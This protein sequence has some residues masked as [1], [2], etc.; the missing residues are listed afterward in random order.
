MQV[1]VTLTREDWYAYA[2]YVAARMSVHRRRW[3]VTSLA[4]SAAIAVALVV[5]STFSGWHFDAP[6]ALIVIVLIYAAL[7][8]TAQL[9]RRST[10]VPDAW[11]GR[12]IYEFG[13]DGLVMQG[14]KSVARFDWNAISKVEETESHLILMLDQLSGLVIPKRDLAGADQV[15]VLKA[16][17]ARFMTSASP[18]QLPD[19]GS[20]AP[21]A[22]GTPATAARPL[23]R[24]PFL[25]NCIGGLRLVAFRSVDANQFAPSARQALLFALIAVLLWIGFDRVVADDGAFFSSYG[26]LEVGWLALVALAT[27]VLFTPTAYGVASLSRSLTACASALPVLTLAA[28]LLDYA[29]QDSR[30]ARWVGLIVL[31]GAAIYLVRA[32][33]RVGGEPRAI[34][35]AGSV[36]VVLITSWAY[37]ATVSVRPQFWYS[38]DEPG[39]DSTDWAAAEEQMYRQ[40]ELI[41]RALETLAPQDPAR[42]D[43]YFL[44]F[45]GDGDQEVFAREVGF[46]RLALEKRFDLDRHEVILANSPEP[47]QDALL[48]SSSALR[49]VLAGLGRKMDIANDVLLLYVTSHGSEDGSVAVSQAGMPFNDLYADDL[50]AALDAAH[51]QWRILII[52]ACYS[53]SFIEPLENEQTIIFTAARADRTSF[54]CSDERELT[55]FG[56]ALFRDALPASDSLLDAFARTQAIIAGREKSEGLTPSEPQLYVGA[57]M[58]SKLKALGIAP[59][60]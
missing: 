12:K 55:Y 11:L 57:R 60:S 54:G 26:L 6:T 30:L 36:A 25:S 7:W 19:Q 45:A 47:K 18:S 4:V 2:R 43:S 9:Q 20:I 10:P 29:A 23:G 49:R 13:P 59:K 15:E 31:A 1:D 42:I 48:A 46:A 58:R 16:E 8:G 34:A 40:P 53:G 39:D 5:Q 24:A 21:Q 3:W 27:F 17:I 37:A 32:K 35:L 44:G 51:I 33:V 52:S 38:A 56:E 28:L 41:D 22:E 14:S 50:K